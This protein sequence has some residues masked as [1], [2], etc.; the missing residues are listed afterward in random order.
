M[1]MAGFENTRSLS[2]QGRGGLPVF[3]LFYLI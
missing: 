1:V 2:I 3:I